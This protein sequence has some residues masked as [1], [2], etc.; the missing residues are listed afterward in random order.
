MAHGRAG[1]HVTMDP[2]LRAFI[3]G[4]LPGDGV[5]LAPAAG[6]TRDLPALATR[7]TA[8]DPASAAPASCA[9]VLLVDDEVSHAAEHAEELVDAVGTAL[10]A[11]GV[12]VATVRNRVYADAVCEPL[13]ALRGY[14]AQEATVLLNHRGFDVEVICAPGATAGLRGA[15]GFDPEDDR[16][17][18]LLDAGPRLLLVARAPR[19][20]E[21]RERV[22][23]DSR[24]RKIAAAAVICQDPSGRVLVV[25]DRFKRIW[26][27]PGG[28]VDAD[29]DPAAAAQREA[30]EEAG[31]KVQTG[32]L[33]GV[34][35]SRWPD[36]L[37]F[38]FAATPIE[39]AEH[40][41]PV[42]PHEISMVE[43]LPLEEALARVAS[44]VAFKIRTCLESPGF[45][46]VQ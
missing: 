29:E 41:T 23:F 12:L 19:S 33:L 21:E 14:S 24:P 44:P 8:T 34:F 43:W 30:W 13:D 40:P 2:A 22:F 46:W 39:V 15:T 17:P 3:M 37:V 36:R 20:A 28:V 35:A 7:M 45:T 38:V 26:T 9:V 42:H 5:I 31:T 4:R 10:E 27:I 6:A 16:R 25:H 1:D 32:R 11:G 18:G